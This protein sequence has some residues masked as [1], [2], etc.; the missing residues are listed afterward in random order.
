MANEKD[1]FS[2]LDRRDRE[3]VR[4]VTTILSGEVQVFNARIRQQIEILRGAGLSEQ[5]IIGLLSEDLI[6]SGRIFGELKMS[7][8]SHGTPNRYSKLFNVAKD[9]LQSPVSSQIPF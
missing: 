3:I 7:P 5:S 1:R 2:K 9:I 6:S 4:W 8:I